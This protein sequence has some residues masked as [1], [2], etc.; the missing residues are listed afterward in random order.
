MM[1]NSLK[2]IALNVNSIATSKRR[3][4]LEYFLQAQKPDVVL[5][6]ETKLNLRNKVRFASY[7][8]YRND[9]L[10]DGGGGTAVLVKDTIRHEILNTPSLCTAE[11]SV[12][13][14][15]LNGSTVSIGSIYNPK[16]LLSD[17]LN[18]LLSMDP[19]IFLAG[20]FNAKHVTWNNLNNNSNGNTLNKFLLSR[21]N[22]QIHYP[23]EFTC[24]RSVKN[25][26]TID[27]A[28][29]RNVRT[30]K[31]RVLMYDSDHDAV[32]YLLNLSNDITYESPI[33]HFMYKQA[34]WNK[35]KNTV[36]DCL[37]HAD[38][39]LN[40]KVDIDA[41]IR[42][43]SE[44]ILNG[45]NE[46]IPKKRFNGSNDFP[47]D[48]KLLL[49]FKSK[50]RRKN[51]RKR[52]KPKSLV[53]HLNALIDEKIDNYRSNLLARKLRNIRPDGK[54]YDNI[55]KLLHNKHQKPPL[56]NNEGSII[57]NPTDQANTFAESFYK[58]HIQ[59]RELGDP[60]FSDH[61]RATVNNHSEI[62]QQSQ[63]LYV[64]NAEEVRLILK[65]L[66]NKKS[67]GPD[68]IPNVVIKKLPIICFEMLAEICN[69][70]LRIGYFPDEWKLA[71]V[72]PVLK[73]G[74]ELND[75]GNY[76][77][78]SLLCNLSKILEKV[79]Y[80]R[81]LDFCQANKIIPDRQFGFRPEH[82]TIHVLL[83]E[84]ISDGFNDNEVTIA[85]LLDIAKAFDLDRRTSI[86][87]HSTELP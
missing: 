83:M 45:M 50:L 40:S 57:S 78:I 59:N 34:N 65:S 11:A 52:G 54:M 28:I 55:G 26:S 9:R 6:S 24:R 15:Q 77:P 38:V 62:N 76:R 72:L 81:I 33:E 84:D 70:C 48:V 31:P 12:M 20:D 85:V 66:K 64:T 80:K 47:K 17:D 58:I 86:Q 61:V 63:E 82:S 3:M 74:K 41:N 51:H 71:H 13:K 56:I 53:N 68:M 75:P 22:I 73:P 46:S 25:P 29:S 5:L 30:L 79:I 21:G 8:T 39:P 4:K 7:S 44:A 67:K 2:V 69:A 49:D 1:S 10:S 16:K 35:F 36:N 14:L 43:L 87:T 27:I 37:P 42:C 19:D 32:E 18:K 60:A 23:D